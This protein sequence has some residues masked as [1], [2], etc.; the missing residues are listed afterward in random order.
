MN[1]PHTTF[2]VIKLARTSSIMWDMFTGT[3]NIDIYLKYKR[4]EQQ[5]ENAKCQ[6]AQSKSMRQLYTWEQVSAVSY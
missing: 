4:H 5:K 2:E 1:V 6:K 3:G